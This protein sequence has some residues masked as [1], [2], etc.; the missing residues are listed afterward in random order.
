MDS[1]SQT[2][3]AAPAA[4]GIPDAYE[5]FTFDHDPDPLNWP[6]DERAEYVGYV[7]AYG[8]LAQG[9]AA[10]IGGRA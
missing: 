5:A 2:P 6:M 9:A 7:H 1:I 4:P 10:G 3:T 8:F